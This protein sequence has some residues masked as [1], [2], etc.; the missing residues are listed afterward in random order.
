MKRETLH[1]HHLRSCSSCGRNGPLRRG[2]CVACYH[3]ARRGS[4]AVGNARCIVC[5]LA[6]VRMLRAVKLAD[7]RAIVACRNHAFLIERARP[8][9]RSE[10]TAAG[11]CAPS[12][13]RAPGFPE[14]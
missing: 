6:D 7:G 1:M 5:E 13:S 3:R 10:T 4:P 12:N 2:L 8:R 11:I 9:P 14:A